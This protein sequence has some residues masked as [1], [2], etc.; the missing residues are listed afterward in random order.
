[1]KTKGGQVYGVS[2]I[3]ELDKLEESID[4]FKIEAFKTD[5]TVFGISFRHYSYLITWH[6]KKIYISGDT[7]EPETI[8]KMENIDL[9]FIPYWILK[10][11]NEQD[12]SIDAKKFVIYHLYPEQIPSAKENWD[13]VENIKPLVE[14]GEKT[15][16]EF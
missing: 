7:T 6:G 12:I 15:T 16:I 11:A 3:S 1:M 10:N 13:K 2:N 14:Q 9:A 4:N 8:G 5:H